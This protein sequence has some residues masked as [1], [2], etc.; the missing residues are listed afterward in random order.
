MKT[1][2]R[3]LEEWVSDEIWFNGGGGKD[4][5]VYSR[6]QIERLAAAIRNGLPAH[7]IAAFNARGGKERLVGYV[8]GEVLNWK[9]LLGLGQERWA[10]LTAERLAWYESLRELI[11]G[12]KVWSKVNG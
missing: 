1:P 2:A 7:G 8:A 9:E 12:Y 4:F 3:Y 5:K 11:V 10:D 6:R